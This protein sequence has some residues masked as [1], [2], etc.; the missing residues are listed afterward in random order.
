MAKRIGDAI[1]QDVRTKLQMRCQ[2][3]IA[4]GKLPGWAMAEY[5]QAKTDR[6]GVQQLT[7]LKA[8]A[9]GHIPDHD[10]TLNQDVSTETVTEEADEWKWMNFQELCIHV[11]AAKSK[12]Q[13]AYA[14]LLWQAA[15]AKGGQRPHPMGHGL[16][17][18]L[19]VWVGSSELQ[20]TKRARKTAVG[21]GGDIG[22]WH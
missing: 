14:T 9:A 21:V 10:V 4:A 18:Q 17:P 20:A 16:K 8:W 2:R 6:L 22:Q 1:I 19:R 12:E 13:K 5:A 11:D 3:A 15:K 7:F